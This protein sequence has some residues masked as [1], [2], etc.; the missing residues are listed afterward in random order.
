MIYRSNLAAPDLTPY[1]KIEEF[2]HLFG[3]TFISDPDFEPRYCGFFTHD[4]AA[5]LYNIARQIR[6]DWVDIGARTGWTAAHLLAAGCSVAAV[7]M[8]YYRADFIARA[9]E[10]LAAAYNGLHMRARRG[11]GDW[12]DWVRVR[13][14][15]GSGVYLYDRL[16]R[17]FFQDAGEKSFD[18]FVIDANHERP[19]PMY[20]TVRAWAHS[21]LSSCFVLHDFTGPAT[22][23][24][25]DFLI[26]EGY[27]CRVY[28]TPNVIALLWRGYDLR[29]FTP[30]DHR[31]DPQ[32]TAVM[33]KR[34]QDAGFDLR[35][36]L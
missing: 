5:I 3:H 11:A 32:I 30:P 20:D 24:A 25:A 2:P 16:S 10:N 4:E 27:N 26:D 29:T 34:L 19:G 17:N 36:C 35:R 7:E 28:W 12:A 15:P 18:G 22:W 33:P 8:E 9:R 23:E 21:K 31:P 6:G 1:F 13:D 14:L